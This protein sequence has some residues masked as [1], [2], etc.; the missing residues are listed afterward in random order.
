[1]F[2]TLM[3][4]NPLPPSVE[5]ST[6][7]PPSDSAPLACP[8]PSMLAEVR[9]E[10]P[11]REVFVGPDGMYAGTRWLIYLAMGG[12]VLSVEGALMQFVHPHAGAAGWGGM[13]ALAR[14][15]LL[16]VLPGFV[17]AQP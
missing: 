17:L 6:S 4:T 9:R 12:I 5:Q 10:S 7:P 8:A 14:M 15:V 16:P 2:Q 1:M 3:D 11:F 13:V